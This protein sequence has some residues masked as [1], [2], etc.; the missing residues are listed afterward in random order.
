MASV[1]LFLKTAVY[2]RFRQAS[3]RQE[4]T[5]RDDLLIWSTSEYYSSWGNDL[6]MSKIV[7]A[8]VNALR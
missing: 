4:Q 1:N 2:R 8:E 3:A 5:D 7:I 6:V